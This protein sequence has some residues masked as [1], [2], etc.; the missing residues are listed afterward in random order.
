MMSD[1]SL[2]I[3]LR[4]FFDAHHVLT[5]A[6]LD[7]EGIGACAVW[8]ASD[9]QLNCFFLSSLHT[10]HGQALRAG[11]EVAFTVQRDRQDWQIIRGVQG[12]G[13]CA[14][15]L[16]AAQRDQAWQVYAHKY[17]IVLQRSP[18]LERALAQALL[19]QITPR[20]LRLIDN[21]RGFGFKQEI[22]LD[23]ASAET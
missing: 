12:R 6:Y 23:E 22:I 10:R 1:E 13:W 20:W 3:A 11:G 7:A 21:Q 2:R 5:L 14:P 19:W 18:A 15:L 8:F 9:A 4:D 16:D 17:P